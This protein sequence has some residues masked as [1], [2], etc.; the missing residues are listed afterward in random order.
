MV[1]MTQRSWFGTIQW[2]LLLVGNNGAV[3]ELSPHTFQFA[4]S[5][6]HKLSPE[7]SRMSSVHLLS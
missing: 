6:S 3:A 4:Q 1:V 2:L 7:V 5:T